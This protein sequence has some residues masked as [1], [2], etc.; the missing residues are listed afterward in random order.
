MDETTTSL[1][2]KVKFRITL[3]TM[4]CGGRFSRNSKNN[5]ES[6]KSIL[7]NLNYIFHHLSITTMYMWI[8]L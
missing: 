4:H 7:W 3:L 8:R 2:V 6:N 1:S 5:W